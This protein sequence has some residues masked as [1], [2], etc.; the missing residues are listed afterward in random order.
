MSGGCYVGRCPGCGSVTSAIVIDNMHNEDA[1]KWRREVAK[2]CAQI[3]RDGDEVEKMSTEQVR[4]SLAR[5]KCQKPAKPSK[6]EVL[7]L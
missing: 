4:E 5:C 3:I 2:F 6:Q 1:V 7:A